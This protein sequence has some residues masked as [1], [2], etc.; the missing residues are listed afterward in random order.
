VNH[1]EIRA[2][3]SEYIERDL[4][5]QQRSEVEA[6]LE[7]CRECQ[8]EL[9]EL[10]A[11]V[12]LLQALPEPAFPAGL[13][14]AA[15]ARIAQGEGRREATVITLFRRV[16]DPRIAA[17]LAAG[18]AGLF[19]VLQSGD[20]QGPS[21]EHAGYAAAAPAA[22][23]PVSIVLGG[24]TDPRVAVRS[25]ATPA[26]AFD[27]Y[28]TFSASTLPAGMRNNAAARARMDEVARQLRG[29][30][31]PHSS[32]FAGHFEPRVANVVLADFQPR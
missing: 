2:R 10:R 12:S 32:S 24:L 31:H 19:F 15:L 23:A 30:G 1:P 13:A 17:P 14:D 16:A 11:M 6:H 9:R 4:S 8:T 26:S 27:G 21:A 25:S 22:P 28:A 3:L 5:P 7:G 18:L 20:V 29:S